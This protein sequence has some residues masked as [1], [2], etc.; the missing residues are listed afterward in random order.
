[1][2]PAELH[3]WLLSDGIREDLEL[4]TRATVVS[5]LIGSP[6]D[7]DDLAR[8]KELDWERLLL[9]GSLLAQATER[10]PIEAALRIT[11]A[12]LSLPTPTRI[13]DAGV[14]LLQKLSN[15][16]AADLA[17]QRH[18]LEP[19]LAGRLGASARLEAFTR[20]LNNSILIEHSGEWLSVN[21][22]GIEHAT[23]KAGYRL[24]PPQRQEKHSWFYNGS[25]TR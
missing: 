19:G 14:I 7:H 16:R 6:P 1:M 2:K 17:I 21:P 8:I 22:F 25:L 13:H 10:T 11:T 4:V 5:E 23:R 20:E 24:P 9:A 15:Y 3:Q 18:L 12:A